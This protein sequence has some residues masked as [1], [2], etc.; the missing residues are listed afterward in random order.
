MGQV[1]EG[2]DR[3]AVLSKGFSALKGGETLSITI[4]LTSEQEAMLREEAEEQSLGVEEYLRR[5]WLSESLTHLTQN[6]I[7]YLSPCPP[8]LR[9]EG[10]RC[11]L[12]CAFDES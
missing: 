12:R 2:A 9:R 3:V 7:H 11:R 4:E 6:A 8:P 10:E 1:S 5:L